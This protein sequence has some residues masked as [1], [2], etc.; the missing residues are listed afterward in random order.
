MKELIIVITNTCERG[1]YGAY[2]VYSD[3]VG[4]T[5]E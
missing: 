2:L 4:K 1:R 5:N 3:D